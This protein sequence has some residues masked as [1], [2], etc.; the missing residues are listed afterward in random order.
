MNRHKHTI[1]TGKKYTCSKHKFKNGDFAPSTIDP[2]TKFN[3]ESGKGTETT[4][5]YFSSA[6]ETSLTE[7]VYSNISTFF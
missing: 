4:A 6:S 5:E 1:I 7:S 3:D 2:N